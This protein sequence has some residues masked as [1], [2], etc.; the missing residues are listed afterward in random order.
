MLRAID[1]ITGQFTLSI[2]DKSAR[3]RQENS[4]VR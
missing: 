3:T 1:K 4:Y 2:N